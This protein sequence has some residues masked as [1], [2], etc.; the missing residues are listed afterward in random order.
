MLKQKTKSL[1][2]SKLGDFS[3]ME[4]LAV[5]MK[6]KGWG[7]YNISFLIPGFLEFATYTLILMG[8][9]NDMNWMLFFV[10]NEHL[11]H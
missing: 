10:K 5:K 3:C 4:L 2:K 11:W 7:P 9:I 1:N 8:W 6:T